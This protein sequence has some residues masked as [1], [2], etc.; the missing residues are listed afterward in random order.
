MKDDKEFIRWSKNLPESGCAF[1]YIRPNGAVGG[2]EL[3]P[4]CAVL[5]R[6]DDGILLVR[7][8]RKD[9]SG[10]VFELLLERWLKRLLTPV[11]GIDIPAEVR[12]KKSVQP[13]KKAVAVPQTDCRKNMKLIF[14]ALKDHSAKNNGTFPV[15]AGP[16]GWKKIN[17]KNLSGNGKYFYFGWNNALAKEKNIPLVLD[18]GTHA[19]RVCVLYTDG[20]VRQ[21]TLSNPGH[22]RR[23]ISFLF[24]VH[25]WKMDVFQYLVKQAELLDNNALKKE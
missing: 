8:G 9:I 6:T 11:K 23:V 13:D 14:A 5:T 10:E 1:F 7:N 2:E 16:A 12:K 18:C 3:Q 4:E 22:C 20:T 25:R 24:T 19:D 17:V 15:E 21:F